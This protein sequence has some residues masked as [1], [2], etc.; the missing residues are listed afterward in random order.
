[1]GKGSRYSLKTDKKDETSPGPGRYQRTNLKSIEN[2]LKSKLVTMTDKLAFGC[3][4]EQNNKLMEHGQERAF[5]GKE[6]SGPGTYNIP[7]FRMQ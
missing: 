2:S 3:S 6:G 5:Y 7:P 4:K 1:M